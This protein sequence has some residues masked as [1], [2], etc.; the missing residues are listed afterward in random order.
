MSGVRACVRLG[1][2][3]FLHAQSDFANIVSFNWIN[4]PFLTNSQCGYVTRRLIQYCNCGTGS[5]LPHILPLSRLFAFH[6]VNGKNEKSANLISSLFLS[7]ARSLIFFPSLR[8][9][10]P[11]DCIREHN[12]LI[13]IHNPIDCI[14]FICIICRVHFLILQLTDNERKL[15]RKLHLL[16]LNR[17]TTV[18]KYYMS[19]SI[20]IVLSK[21]TN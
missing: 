21:S 13:Q 10:L 12:H 8:E 17:I 15:Q 20:A 16:N 18:M 5:V 1:L 19:I 6:S 2:F 3:A 9:H 4:F 11:I 14:H 7:L